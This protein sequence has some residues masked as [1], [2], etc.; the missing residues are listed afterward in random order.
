MGRVFLRREGGCVSGNL[1]DIEAEALL[2][3]EKHRVD[4]NAHE[5]PALGGALVVPL[6]SADGRE[7]FTFDVNR[8]KINLNNVTYQH[9]VRTVYVLGRRDING[10]P[11]RNPD[12]DEIPCPHI[13]IYR[14]GFGDRW[15]KPAPME[16]FSVIG[17]R[18]TAFEQFMDLCNITDRP[19]IQAG[20]FT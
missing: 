12:G 7:Y 4:N 1:S 8:G 6:V 11:H 3:M 16:R 2:R 20:L 13:H 10:P 9:R 17:S 15:A 19:I 14:E 18:W 5:F